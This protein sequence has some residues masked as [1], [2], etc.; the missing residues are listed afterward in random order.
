MPELATRLS[1]I[2]RI[3]LC[4]MWL[5]TRSSLESVTVTIMAS[6]GRSVQVLRDLANSIAKLCC[7]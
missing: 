3:D 1:K 2:G 6:H 7:L 5:Q 4:F